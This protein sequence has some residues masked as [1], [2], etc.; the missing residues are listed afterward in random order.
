MKKILLL[1]LGIFTFITL[2]AQVSEEYPRYYIKDGQ[3]YVIFTLEQAQKIDNAYD[4]LYLLKQSKLQYEKLD[5]ANIIVVNRLGEQVAELKLK[6]N[7]LE[8]LVK[9]KSLQISNLKEQISKYERDRLLSNEQSI[10]KDSIISNNTK[11]IKK[12]KKQK[13]FGFTFGGGGLV[14]VILLLL[15][16]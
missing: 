5:S 14:A 6:T 1:L 12:L 10:K 15:L 7:T 9:D 2:K 3:T 8:D 16:K 11:Q 4:L 13:F